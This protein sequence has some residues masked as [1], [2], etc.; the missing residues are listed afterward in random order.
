MTHCTIV[1]SCM[2]N[3]MP[4]AFWLLG[5]FSSKMLFYF[6]TLALQLMEIESYEKLLRARKIWE[7]CK[8]L[9]MSRGLA[10]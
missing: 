1:G 2:Y 10:R 3:S 6:Q 5:Y 9:A 7:N 4:S 8:G